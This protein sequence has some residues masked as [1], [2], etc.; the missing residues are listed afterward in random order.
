MNIQNGPAPQALQ[1]LPVQTPA[2]SSAETSSTAISNQMR[3]LVEARYFMAMRNPRDLDTV[4]EKLLKECRR[5]GFADVAVYRKPIGKGIEGAS[6][7]FAEAAI[8]CMTNI[9]TTVITVYDD[10]EK[11]IV[12]VTLC[13]IEANIPYSQDVTVTKTVERS[14]AKRDDVIVKRRTNSQGNPVFILEATDDDILNKQNALISKAIRTLALRLVPGDIVEECLDTVIE[15]QT[16]K[17]ATDPDAAKRKIFDAFAGIGVRASDIK[18]YLGH[19]A[20]TLTP[21]ELTD[22]RGLFSAIR[23]GET[24]WQDVTENTEA[25]NAAGNNP[26]AQ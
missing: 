7:R 17:A 20:E 8:R 11:R 22:L 14:S 1:Q 10:Q 23:D 12:R 4:R 6:I 24:T 3:A 19:D 21:K 18:N 2:H 13:D 16:N 5:P 9:E 26:T 25:R 15:T